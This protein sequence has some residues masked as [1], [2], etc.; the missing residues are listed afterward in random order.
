MSYSKQNL[1]NNKC[2]LYSRILSVLIALHIIIALTVIGVKY[3][4][5]K[6]QADKIEN[7]KEFDDI[8]KEVTKLILSSM[9]KSRMRYEEPKMED[10][11]VEEVPIEEESTVE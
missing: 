5:N 3:V 11:P 7:A 8:Q 10:L 1:Q 9:G 4:N 2:D 6:N